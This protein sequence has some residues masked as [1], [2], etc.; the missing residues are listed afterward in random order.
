MFVLST[1]PSL[2]QQQRTATRKCMTT[3]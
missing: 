3:K 1:H 2:V